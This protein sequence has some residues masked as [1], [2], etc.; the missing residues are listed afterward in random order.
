M[1]RAGAGNSGL[2]DAKELRICMRVPGGCKGADSVRRETSGACLYTVF[3]VGSSQQSELL[4]CWY[5]LMRLNTYLVR[6]TQRVMRRK[7]WC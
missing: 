3:G 7:T 6:W 4:H 2:L 1:L 5:R